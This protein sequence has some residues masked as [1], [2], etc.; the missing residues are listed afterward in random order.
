MEWL[1]VTVSYTHLGSK[2]IRSSSRPPT[3]GVLD[4]TFDSMFTHGPKRCRYSAEEM[5]ALTISALL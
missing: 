5:K 1:A 2:A 4:L 3:N